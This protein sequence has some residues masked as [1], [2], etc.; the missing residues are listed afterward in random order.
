MLKKKDKPVPFA[1]NLEAD[2]MKEQVREII[3]LALESYHGDKSD[4]AQFLKRD[5][6]RHRDQY[7]REM[8]LYRT[9][10]DYAKSIR[11]DWT[12]V[13]VP[14]NQQTKI[15]ALREAIAG[16]GFSEGVAS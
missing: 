10:V 13:K 5:I 11:A 14:R 7:D 3:R 15:F 8:A 9:E 16:L 2:G 1:M 4:A 12:Q 6:T